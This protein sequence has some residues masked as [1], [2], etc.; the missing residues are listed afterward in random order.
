MKSSS[1]FLLIILLIKAKRS[2]LIATPLSVFLFFVSSSYIIEG[3]AS[4]Y[5]ECLLIV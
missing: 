1:V 3:K 2:M 4:I 5:K